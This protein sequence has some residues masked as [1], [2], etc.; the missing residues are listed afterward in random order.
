MKNTEKLVLAAAIGAL[1]AVLT[2]LLSP[3]SYGPLQ[4]RVSEVLCI[5]PYFIPFTAWGLF[6]GCMIANLV[7]AA[8]ILDVVFGSLATLCACLCMASFG[9]KDIAANRI[10]ACLMPVLWNGVIVGVTLTVAVAGLNPIKEFGA[11]CIYAGQVALGELGVMFVIGL[12]LM[13]YLPKQKFFREFTGK[14][15]DNERG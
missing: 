4:F 6:F 10:L 1:Y 3:I 15:L 12:P 5:L 11:F 9:K 8:G 13:S 7:S 14:F 2:M